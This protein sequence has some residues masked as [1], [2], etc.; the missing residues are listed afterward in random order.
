[1]LVSQSF[2][3][4][5]S[6]N[7][8]YKWELWCALFLFA[9]KMVTKHEKKMKKFLVDD[10]DG[11]G[12]VSKENPQRTWKKIWK[13]VYSIKINARLRSFFIQ[14]REKRAIIKFKQATITL[15]VHFWVIL[16]FHS[17]HQEK[18]AIFNI[19]LT[20]INNKFCFSLILNECCLR[21]Y[22]KTDLNAAISSLKWKKTGIK[23]KGIKESVAPL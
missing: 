22:A 10:F 4:P 23:L 11:N 5:N 8:V 1:M 13:I 12:F 2:P 20:K 7:F 21:S 3:K 18:K 19:I 15:F 16:I 14:Y 17:I 6:G 9:F